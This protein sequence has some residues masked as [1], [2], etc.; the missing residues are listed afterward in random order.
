MKQPLLAL[1]L[2]AAAP[3]PA[4][5]AA[6]LNATIAKLV[7]FGTRHTLSTTTDRARGIGA[8]R[9]WIAGRFE[10]IAL[11]CNNCIAVETVGTM[12]SGPRAPK[13]VAIEDVI[14]IQRGTRDPDR[15]VIVQAHL[16][17]RVNDVMDAATNAPGANDDASGVALVMEAAR[18]LSK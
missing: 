17:S 4:P 6:S 2:V 9:R 8:A 18:L 3:A 7:S 1:L 13:G 11:S 15:V 14:A 12:A 10:K 5:D 16:D